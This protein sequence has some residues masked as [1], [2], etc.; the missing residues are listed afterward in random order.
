MSHYL[1]TFH[2]KTMY[3]RHMYIL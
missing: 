3:T 2:I 1:H